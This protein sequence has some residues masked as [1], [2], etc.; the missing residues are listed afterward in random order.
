MIKAVV[1]DLDGVLIEAKDWHYQALNKALSHF[2]FQISRHE[3]LSTFDGLPTHH[4]LEI[5]SASYGLPGS[6]HGLINQ[7]KQKYTTG[8]IE[9][10]CSPVFDHQYA[11]G[12]LRARGYRVAC[13]SNSIRKSIELMLAKANL[14]SKV[15]FFMSAEDV[16]TGKPSPDIYEAV[17]E[18]LKLKPNEVLVLEDNVNGIQAAKE[19]GAHVLEVVSV[20][21]VNLINISRAIDLANG[22]E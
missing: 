20:T 1:F 8:M 5:L 9:N 17:F 19:A 6:L 13:A 21:D 2:G 18:R 22:G 7:L 10:H 4:K 14:L 11:I 16:A 3:H 12:Q 15:E